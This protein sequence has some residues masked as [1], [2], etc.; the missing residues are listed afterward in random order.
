MSNCSVLGT[1]PRKCAKILYQPYVK[2]VRLYRVLRFSP[3]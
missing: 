1:V 2:P 3:W